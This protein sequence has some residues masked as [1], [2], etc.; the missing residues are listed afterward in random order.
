M[1]ARLR[2]GLQLQRRT[3]VFCRASAA[4]IPTSITSS[5]GAIYAAAFADA[6]SA[7]AILSARAANTSHSKEAT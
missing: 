7:D 6:A 3:K 1:H 4:A 2:A 5:E